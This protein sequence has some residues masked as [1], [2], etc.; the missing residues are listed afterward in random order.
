VNKLNLKLKIAIIEVF[1][2]LKFRRRFYNQFQVPDSNALC[3]I[4]YDTKLKYSRKTYVVLC[5]RNEI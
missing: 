5:L 3:I 1:N 4:S 2:Q